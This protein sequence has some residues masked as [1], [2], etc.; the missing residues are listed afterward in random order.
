MPCN[1]RAT[2]EVRTIESMED[3]RSIQGPWQALSCGQAMQS[4]EWLST[5]WTYY[6]P[7]H[8][9]QIVAVFENDALVGAVPWYRHSTPLG[10]QLRYLGSGHVCSD[11]LTVLARVDR[12]TEVEDKIAEYLQCM[13]NTNGSFLSSGKQPRKLHSIWLDGGLNDSWQQR[14]LEVGRQSRFKGQIKLDTRSWRLAIPRTV[15]E[16][17]RNLKG[18][19]AGRKFKKC[20]QRLESGEV[21]V[22]RW[23][24]PEEINLGLDHLLR[25]HAARRASLGDQGCLADARF[26]P[27]LRSTIP[28]LCK[29]DLSSILAAEF[30]GQIVGAQ[31]FLNAETTWQMYQSGMDP[32]ALSCEP[33]HSMITAAIC[34]AIENDVGVIDF[35]RGDEPYKSYWGAEPTPLI[36]M[37]LVNPNL[38]AQAIE[39]LFRHAK[40]VRNWTRSVWQ[41]L[42]GVATSPISSSK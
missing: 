4:F 25:L 13:L 6:G 32:T 12:K 2:F 22:H 7:G 9:L 30:E 5:W 35:L 3:W 33:G 26:E 27:F 14:C 41:S 24:S 23:K 29:Q 31:L 10:E 36:E 19:S 39:T 37:R 20:L 17:Q 16:M 1:N 28:Q 38:H 42:P 8:Q 21:V 15:A 11:Y 18:S 40:S 34:Q